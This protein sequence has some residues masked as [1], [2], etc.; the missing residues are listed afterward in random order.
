VRKSAVPAQAR[1][2][3]RTQQVKAEE[4]WKQYF[5]YLCTN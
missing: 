4:E 2:T 3:R 5:G 1:V